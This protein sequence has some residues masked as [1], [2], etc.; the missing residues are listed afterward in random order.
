MACVCVYDYAYVIVR[1]IMRTIALTRAYE[2]G[3]ISVIL[4]P[5]C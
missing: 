1:T 4:V 3:Q 2:G 5:K